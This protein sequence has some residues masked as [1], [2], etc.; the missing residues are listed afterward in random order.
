MLA[1]TQRILHLTQIQTA[2]FRFKHFG[3]GGDE[4]F[5]SRFLGYE[6]KE[7]CSCPSKTFRSLGM[8]RSE[9]C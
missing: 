5:S 4:Y 1:T 7:N 6:M 9:G 3:S 2:G 8:L